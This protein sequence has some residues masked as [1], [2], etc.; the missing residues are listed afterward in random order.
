MDTKRR[1][2]MKARDAAL[3]ARDL[4]RFQLL[5]VEIAALPMK[6]IPAPTAKSIA[7]YVGGKR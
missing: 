3:A 1:A 5:T 7:R 4:K 6:G 2:L